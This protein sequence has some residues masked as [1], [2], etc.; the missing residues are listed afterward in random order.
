MEM[1]EIWKKVVT[2][3]DVTAEYEVSNLGRVKLVS[4]INGHGT[5]TKKD[6]ILKPQDNGT[7]YSC[8]YASGKNKRYILFIHRL[9]AKAFIDNPNNL[10]EVNHLDYDRKNNVVTNLEWCTHS[11]NM[12]HSRGN[13]RKQKPSSKTCTGQRYITCRNNRFRV[14][15]TTSRF[16]LEKSFATLDEAVAFRNE[17]CN[18]IGYAV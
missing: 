13:L 6:M 7:G 11:Q 1:I 3:D 14:C 10:N 17:V 15:F 4:Y 9:V 2:P 12:Q 5:I 18:E 8:I 16:R